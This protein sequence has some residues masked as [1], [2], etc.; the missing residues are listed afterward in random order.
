MLVYVKGAGTKEKVGRARRS[1]FFHLLG[2]TESV[3]RVN[4]SLMSYE[5]QIHKHLICGL[6]RGAI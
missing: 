3:C 4:L 1:V 6:N 2:S 5:S